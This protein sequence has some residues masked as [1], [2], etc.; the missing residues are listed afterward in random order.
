VWPPVSLGS[1]QEAAVDF[2]GVHD[3]AAFGSPPRPGGSTVRTVTH[4][5]WSEAGP[6]LVFEVVANAFL[7]RMIR[8]MVS[9]QVDIAQGRLGGKRVADF[10]A[11]EAGIS[12]Q[13]LAPANGLTL[14]EVV[15]PDKPGNK[16]ENRSLEEDDIDEPA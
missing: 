8:R 15:Y 4:A 2:L 11:G 12:V 5:A 13:G 1:L 10:L 6:A 16:R 3:Y 14:V 7:Y 9:L